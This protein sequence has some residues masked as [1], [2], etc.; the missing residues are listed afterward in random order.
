MNILQYF[1]EDMRRSCSDI[2]CEQKKHAIEVDVLTK[3][4]VIVTPQKEDYS[5]EDSQYFLKVRR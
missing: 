3:R 1:P 5:E 2:C 4:V